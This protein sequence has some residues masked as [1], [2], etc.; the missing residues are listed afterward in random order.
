[1][2][3]QTQQTQTE[4]SAEVTGEPEQVAE[5]A[6]MA[7]NAGKDVTIE[8]G[9]GDTTKAHEEF[10]STRDDHEMS[11]EATDHGT[12]KLRFSVFYLE[13]CPNDTVYIHD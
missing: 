5:L 3:T 13:I 1:M 11:V 6:A 8:T 7:F 9:A 4:N 2:T 12:A 10:E